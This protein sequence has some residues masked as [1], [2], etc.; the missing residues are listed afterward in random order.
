MQRKIIY[1]KCY[2]TIYSTFYNTIHIHTVLTMIMLQTK[3][4][5]VVGRSLMPILDSNL[6]SSML[7]RGRVS[8][9]VLHNSS[10]MHLCD[11]TD[12]SN[13]AS[14]KKSLVFLNFASTS[15][16][17]GESANLHTIS[18]EPKF[19]ASDPDLI[20]VQFDTHSR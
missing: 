12:R 8:S 17:L 3:A 14:V 5:I 4:P 6:G 18:Q 19:F 7:E 1:Y 13:S 11:L 10:I 2:N 16:M 20:I 9:V 15:G